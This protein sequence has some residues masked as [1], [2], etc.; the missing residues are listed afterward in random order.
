MVVDPGGAFQTVSERGPKL[1]LVMFIRSG[2]ACGTRFE[3]IQECLRDAQ[4]ERLRQCLAAVGRNGAGRIASPGGA[5]RHDALGNMPVDDDRGWT[6]AS[7]R[8]EVLVGHGMNTN[9]P[10]HPE[11]ESTRDRLLTVARALF[12]ERGYL[13]A[14]MNDIAAQVG[15]RKPSLYNYFSSKEQLFLDL[16]DH[17]LDAWRQAGRPALDAPGPV[18]VRLRRHLHAAVAFAVEHPHDVAICRLA[19][20]QLTG[21]LGRRAQTRLV[22]Q[23]REYRGELERLFAE[24]M[25]EGTLRGGHPADLVLAWSVFLDGILFNIAFELDPGRALHTRLDALWAVFWDGFGAGE[26]TGGVS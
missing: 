9:A 20:A 1:H 18:D 11:G 7:Y 10:L 14:S 25:A 24:A 21:P 16:L 8:S 26:A 13:G 5:S 17:S 22:A 23:S 12:A 2:E 3:R 6:Y 15:V 19:V 4:M